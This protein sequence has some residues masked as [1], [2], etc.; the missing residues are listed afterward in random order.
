MGYG[1][2]IQVGPHQRI[3]LVYQDNSESQQQQNQEHLQVT[4]DASSANRRT[5]VVDTNVL[6]YDPID[7][8]YLVTPP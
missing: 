2:Y 4:N 7:R 8:K 6:L 1:R 3:V 5:Y